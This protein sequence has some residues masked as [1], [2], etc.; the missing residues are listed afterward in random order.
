MIGIV[1]FHLAVEIVFRAIRQRFG[2][3]SADQLPGVVRINHAA[4]QQTVANLLYADCLH[5]A[6]YLPFDGGS[7][8][9][10]EIS[11]GDRWAIAAASNGFEFLNHGS[12]ARIFTIQ[13][14]KWLHELL[15]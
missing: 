7:Q 10:R 11:V 12:N 9:S 4:N 15:Q 1:D 6:S 5:R 3:M 8:V 2:A 14:L 13:S